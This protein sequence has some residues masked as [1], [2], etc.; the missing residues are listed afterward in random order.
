MRL[1]P[2][3]QRI[4]TSLAGAFFIAGIIYSFYQIRGSG[5]KVFSEQA[6][7]L[8]F[9]SVPLMLHLSIRRFQ[10]VTEV[11]A[12]RY[13]YYEA[14]QTVIYGALANVLP[15]PGAFIV[16][17]ASLAN[18]VGMK[19]AIYCNFL[20]Y[21]IWISVSAFFVVGF[22]FP[23]IWVAA[24]SV[25]IFFA[26][27]LFAVFLHKTSG[28]I[29]TLPGLFALQSVLTASNIVRIFLISYCLNGVVGLDTASL[30]QL[31][32]VVVSGTGLVPAG[33]GLAEAAGAALTSLAG[34][35]AA[36]GFAVV[37]VNRMLTWAGLLIAVFFV[38]S[39]KDTHKA[40]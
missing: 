34:D 29:R 19:K 1:S 31:S 37:A 7:A 8:L 22:Y 3:L 15:I 6:F 14:A 11:Y 33:I 39:P 38:R 16:R 30:I 20:A 35:L 12:H 27:L 13:P 17:V 25:F 10:I 18:H 40:K 36:L 5:F 21:L 2:G 26:H 23:A 9:L 4:L 24:F 28:R 32:G